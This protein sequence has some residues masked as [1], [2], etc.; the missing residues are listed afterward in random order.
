MCGLVQSTP[1]G[2]F[3]TAPI[4]KEWKQTVNQR[5]KKTLVEQQITL[6]H[7]ARSPYP[8]QRLRSASPNKTQ[9]APFFYSQGDFNAHIEMSSNENDVS[10]KS[11]DVVILQAHFCSGSK[12]V[13]SRL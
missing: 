5:G 3:P 7:A 4:Q 9:Q 11:T 1:I 13:S 12:G 6:Q 10:R 2:G 8:A